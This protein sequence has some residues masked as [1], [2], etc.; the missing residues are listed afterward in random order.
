[1]VTT[2]FIILIAFIDISVQFKYISTIIKEFR[3]KNP[4]LVGSMN[5]F[6]LGIIKSL[7]KDGNFV[8]IR[9]QI[10]EPQIIKN[11]TV[12]T[13]VSL[14]S[15]SENLEQILN[16]SKNP[17]NRV[18]LISQ[19]AKVVELLSAIA[20]K[21]NI[22][23]NVFILKNDTQELYEAYKI[24][25][26]VVK[27]KLGYIDLLSNNFNWEKDMNPNFIKRRA[28]FHGIVLKGM[29]EFAGSNMNAD[30]S[31]QEKASFFPNNQ[32]YQVTGFTY[33]LFDEVMKILQDRLNFTTELYK[34]KKAGWGYIYPQ[35]NGSYKGTGIIGDI[36]FKRADIALA[37]L[38]VTI[39][40]SLY[41][42]YLP[43]LQPYNT[44][45]YIP[46]SNTESIDFGTYLAPFTSC[47]WIIITLMG[48]V[49]T[50]MKFSFLKV[51]GSAKKFGFDHIWTSFSGF[52][53]GKPF[54]TPI[55]SE[56]SYKTAIIAML[57]CGTLIWISYRARL[58]AELSILE[59]KYPFKDLESF[60][61]TNWR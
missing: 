59:K 31:Y 7:S 5:V 56:S 17:F 13:I 12:N 8:N 1:M 3:F 30:I 40:R 10:E 24:N 14:G 47:L 35:P 53:G 41:V 46:I 61:K 22:H 4:H 21:T 43:P 50:I 25:D 19:N 49:F 57:L 20:Q 16:L 36:F 54:P 28:D 6:P 32:T 37:P 11:V 44:E 33:G 38:Y 42:D 55:D 18:I 58:T 29:V 45:L 15:H 52:L 39:D 2:H 27:R 60:S 34:K 23:Q 51:H 9:T 26:F 48:G